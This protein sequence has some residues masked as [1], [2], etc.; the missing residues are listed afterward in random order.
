VNFIN[1]AVERF[2]ELLLGVAQRLIVAYD[3]LVD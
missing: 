1:I 3:R 2:V